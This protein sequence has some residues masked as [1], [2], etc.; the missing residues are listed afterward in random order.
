MK[1]FTFN[2]LNNIFELNGSIH[3]S[4]ATYLEAV[5]ALNA[6][7]PYAAIKYD[8]KAF[9]TTPIYNYK[10]YCKILGF[11]G[12]EYGDDNFS[13]ASLPCFLSEE[14]YQKILTAEG[15]N[16]DNNKLITYAAIP[17]KNLLDYTFTKNKKEE[18]ISETLVI[19]IRDALN[20]VLLNNMFEYNNS[21]TCNKICNEFLEELKKIMEKYNFTF[22]KK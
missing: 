17:S 9:I 1:I 16:E 18:K 21:Q 19:L 6:L 14:Q 15:I 8:L 5:N 10:A 3:I 20:K 22:K 13:Y 7:N 2:K 11:D 12:F 4:A